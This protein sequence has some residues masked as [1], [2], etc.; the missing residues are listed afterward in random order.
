MEEALAE[1]YGSR[2]I[3]QGVRYISSKPNMATYRLTPGGIARDAGKLGLG[4]AGGLGAIYAGSDSAART[5]ADFWSAYD[6]YRNSQGVSS[7]SR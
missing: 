6:D 3:P 7:K 2:S 1:S 5:A 4:A